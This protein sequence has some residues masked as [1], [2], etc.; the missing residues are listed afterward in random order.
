[1]AEENDKVVRRIKAKTA[2]KR[3]R[4]TVAKA[5]KTEKAD[6]KAAVAAKKDKKDKKRRGE[7]KEKGESRNYFVGAWRELRQVH[8]T[9]RRATWKLTLAVILFSVFFALFVLLADWVFNLVVQ[10]VIL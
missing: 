5:G 8:W 4:A 6:G 2:E 7:K 3:P 1:M 9:N 10:E